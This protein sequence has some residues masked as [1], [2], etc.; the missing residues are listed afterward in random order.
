MNLSDK[1]IWA[2]SRCGGMVDMPAS[3]VGI[4]SGVW[5]SSP[6]AGTNISF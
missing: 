5:G 3:K 4:L 2:I 6:F 1:T